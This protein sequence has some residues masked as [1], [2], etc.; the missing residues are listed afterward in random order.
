M[1]GVA[2]AAGVAVGGAEADQ[3]LLAGG[4]RDAVEIDRLGG[5]AERGVGHRRGEPHELL[6][7]RREAARGPSG[8]SAQL[9]G[10]VEQG[11]DPVA[12]EAGG[13]VVAGDDQLEQARQ[14]LLRVS[15]SPS[16]R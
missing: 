15:G 2:E 1:S 12:D 6:D 14:Q 5:H 13:G 4:D 11:D 9:V 10:V 3:H 7:R 8:S 16:W